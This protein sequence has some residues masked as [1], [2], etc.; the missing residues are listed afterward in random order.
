MIGSAKVPNHIPPA[1]RHPLPSG[2]MRMIAVVVGSLLVLAG[3]GSQSAPQGTT[4]PQNTAPPQT[5]AAEWSKADPCGLLSEA[6]I[7]SY[8]GPEAKTTGTKTEKFNRPECTWAGKDRDQVKITLWVPPA[9]D[10][11]A[12]PSKRTLPVGGKTG[13]ITTSTPASC[14]LEVDGGQAF[15]S[16]DAKANSQTPASAAG[17]T[18]CKKVATTLSGVVD[19]LGW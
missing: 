9:K 4:T 7:T 18:T 10:V 2:Y 6:E 13:Y 19:K 8:L 5:S 16:M 1:G 11:I 14:L 17:D 3:C 12:S 15:V